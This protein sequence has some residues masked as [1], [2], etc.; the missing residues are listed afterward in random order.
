MVSFGRI[1]PCGF[2]FPFL[3]TGSDGA[4]VRT[5]LSRFG[6]VSSG[7]EGDV[8]LSVLGVVWGSIDV[9]IDVPGIEG[10]ICEEAMDKELGMV[11][12]VVEEGECELDVCGVGSFGAFSDTDFHTEATVF[13]CEDGRFPSPIVSDFLLAGV[14]IF[15]VGRFGPESCGGSSSWDVV[16]VPS[17]FDKLLGVVLFDGRPDF[18]RITGDISGEDVEFFEGAEGLVEEGFGLVLFCTAEFLGELVSRD[19]RFFWVKA[20]LGGVSFQRKPD[21]DHQSWSFDEELSQLGEEADRFFALDQIGFEVDKIGVLPLSG[22]SFVGV[23]RRSEFVY[24]IEEGTIA[25]DGGILVDGIEEG[26]FPV[27][28]GAR[29]VGRLGRRWGGGSLWAGSGPEGSVGEESFPR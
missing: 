12:V 10:S 29:C 27:G 20:V 7:V 23:G 6:V 28:S 2:G 15:F 1:E 16:F 13:L 5:E 17:V 9:L 18:C 4:A 19:D 11:S 24:E 14:G 26:M 3:S 25:L 22:A 8:G 21:K